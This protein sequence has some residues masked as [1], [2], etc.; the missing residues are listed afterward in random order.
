M[1]SL[2]EKR[3]FYVFEDEEGDTD[4]AEVECFSSPQPPSQTGE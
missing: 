3:F 2:K 1:Y 4:Y